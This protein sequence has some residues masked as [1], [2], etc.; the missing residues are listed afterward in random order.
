MKVFNIRRHRVFDAIREFISEGR[1]VVKE[2]IKELIINEIR[3]KCTPTDETKL[4]QEISIGAS[5]F[6]YT[7]YD[8]WD[9]CNRTLSSFMAHNIAWLD[10]EI[11][12]NVSCEASELKK[13]GRPSVSF[14]EASAHTKR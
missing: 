3:S 7:F 2:K 12:F 5:R 8:K 14:E 9:Q 1:G 4:L 13:I 11:S 6:C 10:G